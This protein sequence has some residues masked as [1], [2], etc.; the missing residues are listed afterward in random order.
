MHMLYQLRAHMVSS[1]ILEKCYRAFIESVLTFCFIAWFGSIG[2]K[3][4]ARLN[5]IV[6]VC[7]RII[8][9]KQRSLADLMGTRATDKAVKIRND[10]TH[11]LT[12]TFEALPSGR[13]LRVPKCRTKRFQSTFIPSVISLLN[14]QQQ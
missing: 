8:G 2:V 13:R 9:T 7:S 10:P 14:A 1:E 5:S 3:E 12:H 4:R 6:N 11:V